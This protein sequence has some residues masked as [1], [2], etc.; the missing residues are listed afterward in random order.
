[1]SLPR[2]VQNEALDHLPQTDPQA[3]RS[4]ADL[5]R[6]NRIMGTCSIMLRALRDLPRPARLIEFGAGDGTL[7][8]RLAQRL[9]PGWPDVELTLLDR[10]H[11]LEPATLDGF[12]KLGWQARVLAADMQQWIDA[13]SADD[14]SQRYDLAIANLFIHHFDSRRLPPLFAAIARRADGFFAC[15]PR[16][17]WWPLMASHLVACVGANAVTRED[18]VLSVHAGFAGVEMSAHWPHAEG[19]WQLREYAAGPF[20]H[21]FLALRNA[22]SKHA[23]EARAL[24]R[25]EEIKGMSACVRISMP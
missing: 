13:G 8:L 10:Q 12:E 20:S 1:M 2:R 25:N 24:E 16:R 23:W 3:V 6:I 14:D 22:G 11:L 15:E 21:C 19:A 5:R 7:M 17:A 9:A 4:R 18:A